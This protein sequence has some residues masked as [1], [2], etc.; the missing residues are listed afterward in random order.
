[1]MC[2]ENA[3]NPAERLRGIPASVLAAHCRLCQPEECQS[4]EPIELHLCEIDR[5]ILK[6]DQLYRFIYDGHCV[7]CKEY[8]SKS[9]Q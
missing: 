6:P 3:I 5:L 4:D 9:A 2:R 7:S 8:L 1:M